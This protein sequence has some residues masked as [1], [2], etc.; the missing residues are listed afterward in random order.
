MPQVCFYF[1][2][3]Q[4]Y[5][6]RPY[7]VCDVGNCQEYFNKD[8][9]DQN[10][11]VFLKVANK[12]Y[13]PMLTLLLK[14]VKKIPEF[15]F[16]FSVSGVFLEQALEWAPDVVELLQ[17]LAAHKDQVEVLA[18]NYYHSL[19]ALYSEKEFV[20]QVEM[21]NKL[22][23]K[24]LD[25]EP[26][27]FR[28]TE[29]IYN[30]YIAWQVGKLGYKGI[31]AEGVDKHL[32]KGTKTQIWRS[33]AAPSIP[34]L[35][36]HAQ[37]SDDIAFRFSQ[38]SWASWPL[39]AEKYQSWIS[40]YDQFQYI[41]LFMDFETFGEHQ[42]EDTGIF[43]FFEAWVKL[44]LKYDH[45]KF[46]LPRDEAQCSLN[47]SDRKKWIESLPI[48]DIDQPISWADEERDL[49]AWRSNDLQHDALNQI[50]ALEKK[51]LASCDETLITNWRRLLTSD[52]YY[53]M[54]TKYAADGDVHAYFSAYNSPYE[55]YRRFCVVLGDI[56]GRIKYGQCEQSIPTSS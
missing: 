25:V 1:L 45:D 8:E 39:T 15:K 48:Y 43:E 22:M 16:S 17:K 55:A 46:V 41:N 13:R 51:I 4:P 31:L 56:T 49:S 5:R 12:S 19:A 34:V 11:E 50:F 27:I 23:K 38:K 10:K 20:A 2:L 52:H 32:G 28:N 54:C 44:F 40:A 33:N 7:S 36:K 42:W 53:Y 29:L 47:T 24:V 21:H 35:L 14:L 3:H 37:L 30:N 26:Q 18:E 6:L 9:Y